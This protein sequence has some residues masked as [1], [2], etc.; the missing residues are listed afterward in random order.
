MKTSAWV[1]VSCGVALFIAAGLAF[2]GSLFPA[3][4]VLFLIGGILVAYR[5]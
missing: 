5:P 2:A 4:I 3:A 1:W